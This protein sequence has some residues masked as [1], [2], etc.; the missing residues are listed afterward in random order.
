M[1]QEPTVRLHCCGLSAGMSWSSH[2]EELSA[3]SAAT[4]PHE[5]TIGKRFSLCVEEHEA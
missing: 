5:L 3:R 4:H 1:S 2:I